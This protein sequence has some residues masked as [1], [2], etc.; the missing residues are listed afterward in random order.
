MCGALDDDKVFIRTRG[1]FVVNLIVTYKIV[2][3]HCRDE[4]RYRYAAQRA[5]GGVVGGTIID[6]VHGIGGADRVRA[7]RGR[8]A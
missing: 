3:P 8:A 4:H 5:W 1:Y 6:A 2:C 7:R